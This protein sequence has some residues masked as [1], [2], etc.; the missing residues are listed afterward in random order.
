MGPQA[1]AISRSHGACLQRGGAGLTLLKVP[2]RMLDPGKR[3][4]FCSGN[5]TQS[6]PTNIVE[7]FPPS[8]AAMVEKD[9]PPPQ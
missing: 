5:V 3:A 4:W 9:P 8:P 1:Q 7:D 2:R 6:S